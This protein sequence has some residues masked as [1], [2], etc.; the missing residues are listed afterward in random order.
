MSAFPAPLWPITLRHFSSPLFALPAF[1]WVW[2]W[3]CF[4]FYLGWYEP[5]IGAVSVKNVNYETTHRFSGLLP[6][7]R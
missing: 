1:F 6:P 7:R 4:S 2:T 3:N 5:I